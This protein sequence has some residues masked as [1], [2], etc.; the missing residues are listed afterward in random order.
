MKS[1]EFQTPDAYRTTE[2]RAPAKP[3]TSKADPC[4]RPLFQRRDVAMLDR[5]PRQR[6]ILSPG[7]GLSHQTSQP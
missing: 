5:P 4:A 6:W 1:M 7:L 3:R 2:G